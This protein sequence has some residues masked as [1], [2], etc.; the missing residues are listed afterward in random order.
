MSAAMSDPETSPFDLSSLVDA[1]SSRTLLAS[2]VATRELRWLWPGYLPAGKIAM[3]DGD[4]GLGKS[5]VTLAWAAWVTT[6]RPFPIGEQIIRA[7]APTPVPRGVV[8][9]CAEDDLADTIVPRLKAARA[10]LTRVGFVGYKTN[11]AGHPIPLTFP[12]GV[13]QLHQ[14]IRDVDAALVIVDP[15]MAF[16]G[17]EINSHNDA[18][19]RRAL[20]PLKELAEETGVALV[21][22]RHLNKSGEAQAM[23]RGGGSIAF[24]GAARTGLIVTKHP[25]D[26]NKRVLAVIKQNLS[27]RRLTPSWTYELA[28]KPVEL[29][30]GSSAATPYVQWGEQID[31]TA[32]EL[33]RK[34]DART[35]APERD[36]CVALLLELFEE[37]PVWPAKEI[38][39]EL[40]GADFSKGVIE[41]ARKQLAVV[42]IRVRGEQGRTGEWRWSLPPQLGQ[43]SPFP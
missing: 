37:R 19:V 14:T 9:V 38:T 22:I 40:K 32:D 18:S 21:C 3:L 29:S 16:L 39:E 7:N 10:D 5:M 25:D 42:A 26:E 31:K 20:T 23:Y 24:I 17:E 11:N 6:G 4:P 12:D 33:L 41:D 13:N 15:V 34:P 2:D 43:N 1:E 8:L 35:N 30:D 28:N 27:D 36:R